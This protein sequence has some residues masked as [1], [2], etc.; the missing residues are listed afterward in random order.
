MNDSIT[1]RKE[2]TELWE[3]RE[4]CE[5]MFHVGPGVKLERTT[6]NPEW[7]K[8]WHWHWHWQF[9]LLLGYTVGWGGKACHYQPHWGEFGKFEESEEFEAHTPRHRE[10]SDCT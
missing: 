2:I 10:P 4:P 1:S 7:N 6:N 5:P 8:L 9:M 3:H